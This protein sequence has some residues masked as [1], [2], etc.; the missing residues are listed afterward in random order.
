MSM[1]GMT[2]T[3]AGMFLA[4]VRELKGNRDALRLAQRLD[5]Q[6]QRVLVLADDAQLVALDPHL[7]LRRNVLDP[8]AQVAG[9]IVGDPRVQADVDLASTLA[10]GLWVTGFEEL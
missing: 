3:G 9:D 1:A 4:V 10:Y 2:T 5:H 6:L 7:E 8:L